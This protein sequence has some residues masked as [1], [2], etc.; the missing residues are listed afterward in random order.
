MI[1]LK[2]A[3]CGQLAAQLSIIATFPVSKCASLCELST[4]CLMIKCFK[5]SNERPEKEGH[6]VGKWVLGWVD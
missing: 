6:A 3:T 1:L 4:S 2:M 5:L